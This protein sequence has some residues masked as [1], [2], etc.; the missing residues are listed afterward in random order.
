MQKWDTLTEERKHQQKL[1]ML[2]Y[3]IREYK[4]IPELAIGYPLSLHTEKGMQYP[5][6]AGAKNKLSTPP[7]VIDVAVWNNFG[8]KYIPPRPFFTNATLK[9][10][11]QTREFRIYLIKQI[12]NRIFYGRGE[13]VTLERALNMLG[14]KAADVIR[15]E[16]TK[17][18]DPPNAPIT[19]N[20]GWMHR[21]GHSFYIKGKK[22]N[23]PLVDTGLLRKAATWE[24]RGEIKK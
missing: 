9:M 18:S 23:N 12:F 22:V 6:K 17:F 1:K 13:G 7:N 16:I 8:T 14:A 10:P 11:A 21:N 24:I 3:I 2:T 20:G 19:I 4:N 5:G 15:R